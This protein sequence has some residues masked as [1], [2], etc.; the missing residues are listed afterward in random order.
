MRRQVID[1]LILGVVVALAASQ[2]WAAAADDRRVVR[3]SQI[4]PAR[5]V[6]A[7]GTMTIVPAAGEIVAGARE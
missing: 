4:G 5:A 1:G 3:P 6:V 2:L 7:A